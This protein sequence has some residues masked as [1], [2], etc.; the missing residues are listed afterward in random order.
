M[1]F[2]QRC[3]GCLFSFSPCDLFQGTF[4]SLPPALLLLCFFFVEKRKVTF[5]LNVCMLFILVLSHPPF[6]VYVCMYVRTLSLERK[7]ID[8]C[9][10]VVHQPKK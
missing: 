6:Y 2:T 8:C 4:T 9:L 1:L 3:S 7:G 5:L 10:S